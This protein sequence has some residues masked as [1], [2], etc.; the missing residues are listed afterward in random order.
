MK[1]QLRAAWVLEWELDR[2]YEQFHKG[3]LRPYFLPYRWHA[4]K[5]FD[6]MRCLFWN[7]DFHTPLGTLIGVNKRMP[8]GIIPGNQGTR[9]F[10]SDT[11][12]TLSAAI[13]KDLR[14]SLVKPGEMIV[15]WTI[16]AGTKLDFKSLN[17]IPIGRPTKRRYVWKQSVS[18]AG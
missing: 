10:Y 9:L 15:E 18:T 11:P 2:R 6:F 3:S 7:S 5:V 1:T 8:E 13:V 17:A 16:P 4:E 14:F 12:N